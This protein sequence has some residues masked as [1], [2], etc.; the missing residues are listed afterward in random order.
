MKKVLSSLLILFI[1][2]AGLQAQSSF[3]QKGVASYYADKFEGRKT[4]SGATYK[5]NKMT[6]AHL[7]LP[8]GTLVKVTN[9][10]NQ[11]SVEVEIN[12][13]GP[14]V[15]GR[16]IDLSKAAAEELGFIHDGLAE[17]E[18][19]VV[20]HSDD[21]EAGKAVHVKTSEKITKHQKEYYEVHAEK[22][23]PKGFGVQIGTFRELVNMMNLTHNLKSVY[24]K[25]VIVEV[26]NVNGV[27]VYKVIIGNIA[28]HKK[29]TDL[30]EELKSEFPDCF[31]YEF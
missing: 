10:K 3:K 20:E 13:R 4:A 17:V 5:G 18:V 23:E 19:V 25:D 30:R 31:V 2:S 1:F 14:F 15:E 22:R 11:K 26:V 29:A 6:A 27:S 7:M 16:I 9:V 12:D 24:Q 28:N 21:M 8:F